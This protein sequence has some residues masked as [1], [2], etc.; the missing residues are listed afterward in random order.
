MPKPAGTSIKIIIADDHDIF[1][2]GLRRL[3]VSQKDF[4]V[5]AEAADGGEAVA[6]T[7]QLRPDLLLLDL[8]MPRVPGMDALREL[9]QAK[10]ST[11]VVVL[12]AAIHPFDVTS[13]LHMGARGV[14]LKTSPPELLLEGIRAVLDGQQWVGSKVLTEGAR[15]SPTAGAAGLTSREMEI[16]AAIQAGKNNREIAGELSISEETVKRHLSNIFVKVGVSSRLELAL[17]ATGRNPGRQPQS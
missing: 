13:A 10:V 9:A 12:T 1:R 7:C 2:D 16:I 14:I 8:N 17:L 4:V 5:V 15:T 11:H 6:L 3:L